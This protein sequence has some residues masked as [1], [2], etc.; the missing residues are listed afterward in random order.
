MLPPGAQA[1]LAGLADQQA[2]K[3]LHYESQTV[4]RLLI[5]RCSCDFVHPR[6]SD[7][8]EDE[9]HLRERYRKLGVA[10]PAVITALE[11]H[12]RGIGIRPPAGGWFQAL[13]K[14]VA[15]HARNAGPTLFCLNFS[16][17]GGS[18][19]S[20]TEIRP[21][22]VAQVTA[23]PENWLVEGTPTLVAR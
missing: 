22:S 18:L 8:M 9:R 14:F 17:E 4:A 5:G 15:E 16:P 7:P 13:A 12:R 6:V 3:S 10:R 1:D 2:L 19:P 23:H 21:A 11:R 20:T